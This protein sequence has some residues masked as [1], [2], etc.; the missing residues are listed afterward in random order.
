MMIRPVSLTC[1]VAAGLLALPSGDAQATMI[2]NV[3]VSGPGGSATTFIDNTDTL[4][5]TDYFSATFTKVAPIDFTVTIDSPGIFYLTGFSGVHGSGIVNNTGAAFTA[6]KFQLL[7]PPGN[8]L[9]VIDAQQQTGTPLPNLASDP[10]TFTATISGPPNLP[11]GSF[12]DFG[13][14]YHFNGTGPVT[15]T[16][17]LSPIVPEPASVVMTGLGV[18]ALA[19]YGLRR[20]LG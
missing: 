18:L 20:R 12:T 2:T 7:N 8:A 6:L 10:S 14:G 19:G 17:E 16:I 15:V 5:P 4:A 3:F 1:L 9:P 13:V 11:S